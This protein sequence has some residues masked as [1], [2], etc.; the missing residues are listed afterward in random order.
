MTHWVGE[1]HGTLTDQEVHSMLV[2]M[3][4]GW[5]SNDH[6]E[7]KNTQRPPIDGEVVAVT[8]EHLGSEVLSCST[9]RVGKLALLHELGQAKVSN[10]EVTY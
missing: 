10:E 1:A 3:E 4:E 7:D 2:P 6:F 5:D 8:N 9:E